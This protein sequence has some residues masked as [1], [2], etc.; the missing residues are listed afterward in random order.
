[1]EPE[2]KD[3]EESGQIISDAIMETESNDKIVLNGP[4]AD[5][6]TL[7]RSQPHR[8]CRG[9]PETAEPVQRLEVS[10]KSTPS[11]KPKEKPS[12]KKAVIKSHKE[13][14]YKHK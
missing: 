7:T 14:S 5:S 9:K 4:F 6:K 2:A 11:F 3:T 12:T 8:G 1:M 13:R 10:K